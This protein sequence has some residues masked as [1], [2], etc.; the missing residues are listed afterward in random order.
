MATQE[1]RRIVGL[2]YLSRFTLAIALLL[3]ALGTGCVQAYPPQAIFTPAPGQS[4]DEA[5]RYWQS[6]QATET[7]VFIAPTQTAVAATRLHE[8][9]VAAAEGTRASVA[10]E[11][12]HALEMERERLALHMT[13]D[14]ATR[15]A[16]QQ[17]A[18][19]TRE[20]HHLALRADQ[21]ARNH[22]AAIKAAEDAALLDW[23]KGVIWTAVLGL[24]V[25]SGVGVVGWLIFTIG[26]ERYTNARNSQKPQEVINDQRVAGYLVRDTRG[27][28]TIL[29]PNQRMLTAGDEAPPDPDP[30]IITPA[31]EAPWERLI[32]FRDPTRLALGVNAQ[33]GRPVLLDRT[34]TPHLLGA[35]GTGA[36]KTTN[37]L[38]PYLVGAYGMGDHV[39]VFNGKGADF[40]FAS[41][42][43]NWTLHGLNQDET[44][45]LPS[46]VRFLAAARSEAT[47]RGQVLARYNARNWAEL[48]AHAG[49]PGQ[50]VIAIDELVTL[51]DAAGAEKELARAAGDMERAKEYHRLRLELWAQMLYLISQGRKYGILVVA[52][53]TDPTKDVLGRIGM[54]VRRQCGRVAF[55]MQS[56]AAS[57]SFLEDSSEST[58]N[59]GYGRFLYNLGGRT[60]EAIA[61]HP[62]ANDLSR[63][64]QAREGDIS[65]NPLPD[66]LL[67][68]LE[69]SPGR[70]VVA[71]SANGHSNG[72]GQ[73]APNLAPQSQAQNQDALDGRSLDSLIGGMRSL[74][75]VAR[76]LYGRDDTSGQDVENRVLAALRWRVANLGCPHAERI[77]Q[78]S[79]KWAVEVG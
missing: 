75:D 74:N 65:P 39:V 38:W 10:T 56:A 37:L 76:L 54:A 8:E 60:G 11:D 14:H 6:A 73:H 48:P 42:W 4:A 21:E 59:L 62:S 16:T 19:A 23:W 26:Y 29:Q 7:A 2:T 22:A 25:L 70:F 47:R 1:T 32:S 40:N 61:F 77:G 34:R 53:L 46:L 79:S 69:V 55:N 15:V 49:E 44:D 43:A 9:Q 41:G 67:E 51:L 72:N 12:Y 63:Y 17:D 33:T 64:R 58:Q 78:R 13:A 45:V 66:T 50:I 68:A 35:G 27:N 71:G 20:A 30:T 31:I 52:T 18:E 24:V 36:G 3:V 5:Y 28:V 57:R